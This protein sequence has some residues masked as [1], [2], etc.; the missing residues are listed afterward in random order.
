VAARTILRTSRGAYERELLGDEATERA[1]EHVDLP[2]TQDIDETTDLPGHV[3]DVVGDG[4]GGGPDAAVL[5]QDHLPLLRE[6][7]DER[8]VAETKSAV[9][10]AFAEPSDGLEPSTPSLPWKFPA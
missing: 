2:H 9:S 4:S 10:G 7:V 8:G 1:A 3:V 6:S 5:E